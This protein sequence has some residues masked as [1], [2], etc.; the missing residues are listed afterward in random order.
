M[1]TFQIQHLESEQDETRFIK[2]LAK[3]VLAETLRTVRLRKVKLR[4]FE[5]GKKI[6]LKPLTKCVAE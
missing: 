6:L 1:H 5:R 2:K 3:P 4:L